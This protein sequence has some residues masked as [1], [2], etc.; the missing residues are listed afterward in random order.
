MCVF[1]VDLNRLQHMRFNESGWASH[2]RSPRVTPMLLRV[3]VGQLTEG[4][5]PQLRR[6][7]PQPHVKENRE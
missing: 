5:F 1:T 6:W 7:N 2:R 4:N 3:S